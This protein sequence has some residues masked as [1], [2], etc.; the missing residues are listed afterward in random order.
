MIKLEYFNQ[1]DF[2]QLKS[3]VTSPEFNVQ[4][5]G[6][7]FQF[8]LEDEQLSKYIKGV[9]TPESNTYIFKVIDIESGTSIGHIALSKIDRKHL[10][11]RV[12]KVLVGD[13]S[14]RGKG[15]GEQMIR[16]VLHFAFDQLQLHRVCLGVFDF[17][18]GAIAC[19]EKAGFQKEG[20][21]RDYRKVGQEYWSIWEMSILEDEWRS[22]KAEI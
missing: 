10:S 21:L 7:Y 13:P 8:P 16:E 11:A 3:W 5:S 2:H 12:G 14:Y 20:L 18:E 15:I 9:N 1:D 17:N 6:D 19:Y 4:W 22:Q